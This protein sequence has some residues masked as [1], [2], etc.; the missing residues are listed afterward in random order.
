M[1][2]RTVHRTCHVRGVAARVMQVIRRMRLDLETEDARFL[3]AQLTRRLEE[4]ENEIV[5]TDDRAMHR[6]LLADVA[7]LES[8]VRHVE[9]VLEA[10]AD[11]ERCRTL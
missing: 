11:G 4:L 8:I 6:S 10:H 3:H 7:R 2:R 9:G 1:E 5:H